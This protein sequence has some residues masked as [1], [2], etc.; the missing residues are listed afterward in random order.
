[1]DI[2]DERNEATIFFK[3][4]KTGEC[5][6]VCKN[7]DKIYMK[8]DDED[9]RLPNAVLLNCGARE[10]FDPYDEIGEIV[11]VELHIVG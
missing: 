4:I 8:L 5:F 2:I 9:D 10:W 1:M 3:L 7:S 6:K 11:K